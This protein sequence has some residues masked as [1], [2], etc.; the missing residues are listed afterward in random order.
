MR[1]P[2]SSRTCRAPLYLALCRPRGDTSGTGAEPYG[3]R[4]SNGRPSVTSDI[5]SSAV[6]IVDIGGGAPAGVADEHLR[7]HLNATRRVP[8]TASSAAPT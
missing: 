2:V 1:V 3:Y 6:A 4:P 5:C 7:D 8:G